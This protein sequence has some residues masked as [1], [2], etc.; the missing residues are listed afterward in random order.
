MRKD[1]ARRT[2]MTEPMI[3]LALVI[4]TAFAV[5]VA[6][7]KLA[8][9]SIYQLPVLVAAYFLGRRQGVMVAAA[10]VLMVSV[11][12]AVNPAVFLPQPGR[13]PGVALFI[14]GSLTVVTAYVVG[15][16]YEAKEAKSAELRSAYS[17]LVD[18]LSELVSAVD[19]DAQ[20]HSVRVGKIATRIGVALDLP[21]QHIEDIRVAA[22]LHDLPEAGVANDVLRRAAASHES[23]RGEAAPGIG[24]A[25]RAS[26]EHGG[27]LANVVPI[28]EACGENYDGSGRAGL[29][30][31]RIPLG[32]RVLRAAD[33]YDRLTAPTPYGEGLNAPEALMEIER[34]SGSRFDPKVIDALILSVESG[35]P[36]S[37][38][39][40]L[41]AV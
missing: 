26:D 11:Y 17:G 21:V 27:L 36:A 4:M 41:R 39:A 20:S 38:G 12:A 30:G 24:I 28:M 31:D 40:S 23:A 33:A 18:I 5:L 9:L 7:D 10:A 22:L 35:D 37:A 25:L 8:F 14:W 16:L 1:T 2:Q 6:V 19:R 32:A 15:T 29:A 3:L 13:G 34:L